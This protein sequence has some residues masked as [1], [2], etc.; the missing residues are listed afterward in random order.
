VESTYIL[1]VF[2]VSLAAFVRSACGFGYGLISTPLLTF[3]IEAKSVV[4]INTILGMACGLPVLYYMRRHIDPKRAAL[5]SLGSLFGVPLGAYL[6]SVLDP[7]IIQL[8]I[9]VLVIPFSVLLVLGHSYR[10]KRD[11][12]GSGIAGFVSGILKGSTSLGGPPVV[13]FLLNQGLTKER[14]VGTLATYQLFLNIISVGAFA[15]LGVVTIDTLTK[16]AILLPALWLGTYVGI[17]VLPRIHVLLFRR[18]ALSIVVVA[19]L[20]IIATFLMGL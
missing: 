13:L 19:A 3:I 8:A 9:A 15:S 20:I 7:I 5:M 1:A 2:I 6:F 4:V 16:V 18:V 14:F 10:F 11:A 17:K 12:L